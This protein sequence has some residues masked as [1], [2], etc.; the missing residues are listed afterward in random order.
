MGHLAVCLFWLLLH[1][2]R[3]EQ[4]GR[5]QGA[6]GEGGAEAPEVA[7]EL[8]GA[9]ATG[10]EVRAGLPGVTGAPGGAGAN[11]FRSR[12]SAGLQVQFLG[13]D[14]EEVGG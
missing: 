12:R 14:M 11:W 6:Q 2:V 7:G 5:G 4:S 3:P 1:R 13:Q 10:V 9:G 8:G